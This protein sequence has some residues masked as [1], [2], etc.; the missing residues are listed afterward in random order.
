MRHIY[1]ALLLLWSS[2]YSSGYYVS[3]W[4]K[5]LPSLQNIIVLIIGIYIG[6]FTRWHVKALIR[7]INFKSEQRKR[8]LS[9]GNN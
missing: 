6:N 1:L 9:L 7:Y 2:S 3:Q 4:E 8:M 5:D